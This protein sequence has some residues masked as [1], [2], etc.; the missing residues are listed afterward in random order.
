MEELIKR[1]AEAGPCAAEV[2][3]E[4]LQAIRSMAEWARCSPAIRR[5]LCRMLERVSDQEAAE[6]FRAYYLEGTEQPSAR[7]LAGRF[8][9]DKRTVFKQLLRVCEQMRVMLF[10]VDALFDLKG[11]EEMDYKEADIAGKP[12]TVLS[13]RG[14]VLFCYSAWVNDHMPKARDALV[15]Y[16]QYI[17]F[18]GFKGGASKALTELD[19]RQD[20]AAWIRQ[21][22]DRYIQ[23]PAAMVDYLGLA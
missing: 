12:E 10:G 9:E 17:A 2:R 4:Q 14:V 6:V 5:E 23:N 15:R 19:S 8:F 3:E 16:C 7:A 20:G 21:T 18:H 22:Y 13:G 11:A 1:L